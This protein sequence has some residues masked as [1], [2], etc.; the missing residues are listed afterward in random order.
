MCVTLTRLTLSDAEAF[1]RMQ[2]EAFAGLLARYRD[3]ETNPA[4]EMIGRIREKLAQPHRYFYQIEADGGAVGAICVV[5]FGD[6]SQRKRISPLFI[7]PEYQ[8]RGFARAAIREAERLHGETGWA[9]D[10]ILQEEGNCRLYE[11]LG[12]RRTGE[13]KEINERMTLVF[14]EKP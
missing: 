4:C 11:K 10:T 13:T 12:Y 7:L 6:P 8:R 3:C 9:L 5:D 14:Y 1:Q 2:R